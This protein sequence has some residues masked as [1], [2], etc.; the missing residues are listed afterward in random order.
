MEVHW[1]LDQLL[2]YFGTW[3]A[4]NRYIKATGR[5]PIPL[6]AA[7]LEQVWG[8]AD[9]ARPVVW[10]LTLRVGRVANRH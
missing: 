7:N 6:L 5:D 8:N 9:S 2:G 10:P 4:T 3:S 1:T